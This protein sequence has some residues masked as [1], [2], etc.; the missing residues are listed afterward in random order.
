VDLRQDV[1]CTMLPVTVVVKEAPD[2][3]HGR[4]WK[5]LGSLCVVPECH[6]F[7]GV[8]GLLC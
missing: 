8:H 6:T 2:L 5:V 1:A 4:V 3:R 7:Q